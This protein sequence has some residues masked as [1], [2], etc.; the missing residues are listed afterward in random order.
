MGKH[1]SI[2]ATK[3]EYYSKRGEESGGAYPLV[4][5]IRL[6]HFS[7]PLK[8]RGSP[9]PSAQEPARTRSA[10]PSSQFFKLR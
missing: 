8:R 2:M 5:L 9:L 7:F 6:R 4:P 10:V 3:L 1:L